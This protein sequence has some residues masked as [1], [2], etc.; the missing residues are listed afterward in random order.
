MSSIFEAPASRS[1]G[2]LLKIAGAFAAGIIVAAAMMR[3]HAELPVSKPMASAPQA[4]PAQ[5]QQTA[6]KSAEASSP[7]APAVAPKVA[8]TREASAKPAEALPCE[9]RTWPYVDGACAEADTNT[10]QSTRPVRV[11]STDK[12]APATTTAATP[13]Q[14]AEP[15]PT[16]VPPPAQIAAGDVTA[17]APVQAPAPMPA[18]APAQAVS[19]AVAAE[20]SPPRPSPVV[21]DVAKSAA[22][23][24]ASTAAGERAAAK[25]AKRDTK[26]SKPAENTVRSARSSSPL[27]RADAMRERNE[28]DGFSVVQSRVLP[29]GRR[30]TVYRKFDDDNPP[31]GRAY[32]PRSIFPAVFGGN[33]DDDD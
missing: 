4:R 3:V 19:G 1:R 27:Q 17:A 22:S 6:A 32:R 33:D 23:R 26:R 31:T 21:R 24:D 20:P 10:G 25:T 30:V 8:E 12:T 15:Q 5:V 28:A 11:I 14:D 9:Q 18:V 13:P 7:A 16:A 2:P 29:D